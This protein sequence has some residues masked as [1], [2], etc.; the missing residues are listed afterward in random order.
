MR[1]G[2]TPFVDSLSSTLPDTSILVRYHERIDVARLCI[3][4]AT[5]PT[6]RYELHHM[7]SPGSL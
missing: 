6:G 5:V 3:Q 1:G 2:L 4:T 7:N